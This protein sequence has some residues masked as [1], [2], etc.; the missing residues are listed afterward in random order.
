[1]AISDPIGD[2][3]TRLRNG[4]MAKH[5]VVSMPSSRLKVA[6]ATVLKDTGYVRDYQ[7][8]GDKHKTLTVTLKYT[9]KTPVIEGLKRVSTPACRTY[10][11]H[12]KIPR[13]MGGLGMAILSTPRGVMNDQQ[14]R[15]EK[16][17]GEVLAF[18]W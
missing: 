6:V 12:T 15:K 1:M 11:G 13:V 2:M 4:C 8:E 17:G 10:V 16:L 7:V 9:G 14:A 5:P 3:L 18:V